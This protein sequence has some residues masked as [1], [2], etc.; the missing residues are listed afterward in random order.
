MIET[1]EVFHGKS[2][3]VLQE[4]Y[5][6][7]M[8]Q[9]ALDIAGLLHERKRD[10]LEVSKVVDGLLS[11]GLSRQAMHMRVTRLLATPFAVDG[12]FYELGRRPY[13]RRVLTV[14]RRTSGAPPAESPSAGAA[15]R[16]HDFPAPGTSGTTIPS[17]LVERLDR[18]ETMLTRAAKPPLPAYTLMEVLEHI[19]LIAADTRS[20]LRIGD[21]DV[22]VA[23]VLEQL[24]QKAGVKL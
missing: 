20:L 21:G 13:G 3:I 10:R 11:P 15:P 18:I 16:Y 2:R 8:P 7:Y 12:V 6:D 19:R 4:N 1:E 17:D 14:Q 22:T 24:A 9:L 5:G 23:K